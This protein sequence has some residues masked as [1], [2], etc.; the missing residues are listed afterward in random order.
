MGSTEHVVLK[1]LTTLWYTYDYIADILIVELYGVPA[2]EYIVQYNRAQRVGSHRHLPW[3]S[4]KVRVPLTEQR[5]KSVQL[6]GQAVY[7]LQEN[8]PLQLTENGYG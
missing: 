4:L 3:V 7:Y 6:R 5:V 1:Y 8:E 2:G